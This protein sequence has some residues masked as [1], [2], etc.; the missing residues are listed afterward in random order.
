M[1]GRDQKNLYLF[2][3]QDMGVEGTTNGLKAYKTKLKAGISKENI[4]LT[5]I[6]PALPSYLEWTVDNVKGTQSFISSAQDCKNF[7]KNWDRS[8]QHYKKLLVYWAECL[9]PIYLMENHS[10][11]FPTTSP[12]YYSSSKSEGLWDFKVNDSEISVKAPKGATNVIKPQDIV[13][14]EELKKRMKK[15]DVASNVKK[16]YRILEILASMSAVA[17]PVRVLYGTDGSNGELSK[18]FPNLAVKT[19]IV[20][21]IVTEKKVQDDNWKQTE[22]AISS[23]GKSK[24]VEPSVKILAHNFL[25][26][27]GLTLLKMEIS[28][29][30][31]IPEFS[32]GSN[33]TTAEFKGK[34]KKGERMGIGFTFN[35]KFYTDGF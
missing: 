31:G 6:H 1:A 9:G 34:G 7:F 12:V 30:T 24:V 4:P 28:K 26:Y 33:L 11:V 21:P 20:P 27:S 14:N 10:N 17:G 5:A 29:S 8:E 3:P 18:E 19:P 35:N 15:Q 22:Q 32:W 16:L 13:G 23:W 2:D 25:K